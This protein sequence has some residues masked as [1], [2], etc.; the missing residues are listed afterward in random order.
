MKVSKET[1]DALEGAMTEAGANRTL[2]P[3][4]DFNKGWNAGVTEAMKFM[5]QYQKGEGL[6]QIAGEKGE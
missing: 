3:S 5:R 2:A 1:H 6:F 4:N